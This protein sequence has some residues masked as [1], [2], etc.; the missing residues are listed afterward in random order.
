ML[1]LLRSNRDIR[2]VFF[3][4]IVSYLG[5]WFTFVAISAAVYDYTNSYSRPLV[6][7]LPTDS[8][9]AKYL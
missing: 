8:I 1:Q 3:A 9:D 4:Q 6:G 5:D 7:P 2:I